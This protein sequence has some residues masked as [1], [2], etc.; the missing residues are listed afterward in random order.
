MQY[1]YCVPEGYICSARQFYCLCY[2]TDVCINS[3]HTAVKH[4]V[5]TA[6]GNIENECKVKGMKMC[7]HVEIKQTKVI[8]CS[9]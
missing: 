9:R 8:Y 7:V 5:W 2:C 1:V 4:G 6:G 3:F